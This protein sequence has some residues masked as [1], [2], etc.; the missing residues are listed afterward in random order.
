MDPVA[1]DS[2]ALAL[3]NQLRAAR[4]GAP[5]AIAPELTAWLD[6]AHALGL[7]AGEYEIVEVVR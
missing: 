5:D 6:N 2:R 1:T 4:A 3:V 7:G